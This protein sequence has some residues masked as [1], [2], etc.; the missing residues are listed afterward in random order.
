MLL[1]NDKGSG[2]SNTTSL[3]PNQPTNASQLPAVA[4][5]DYDH[6]GKPDLFLNGSLYHNTGTG[7]TETTPLLPGVQNR[8]ISSAAWLDYDNDGLTD[9]LLST[10]NGT[11]VYLNKNSAFDPSTIIPGDKNTGVS[12]GD[13][14]NDGRLDI[15]QLSHDANTLYH[16]STFLVNTL[17]ATPTGLASSVPAEGI[18]VTLKWNRATDAQT[19]SLGLNYNL[20][21]GTTPGGQDIVSFVEADSLYGCSRRRA[22]VRSRPSCGFQLDYRAAPG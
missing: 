10:E 3:L 20:Y 1:H 12:V 19:P 6:D 13:Y 9:L 16:N 22:T 7:F 15:L 11:I 21:V 2:F 18:N 5:A 4:W 17:P 14:D 8:T